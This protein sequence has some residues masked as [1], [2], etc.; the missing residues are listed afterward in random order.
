MM[1]IKK[2]KLTGLLSIL[3]IGMLIF[4]ACSNTPESSPIDTASITEEESAIDSIE[5]TEVQEP[6]NYGAKGAMLKA[7]YTLEEMMQY[8]IED[9]YLAYAEYELIINEM[10]ITKPFSNIIKAE[11]T[12]IGYMEDLYETYGFELPTIDPSQHVVLPESINDAFI[13]GVEAEIINIAMYESFLEQD[14]PEDVRSVFEKLKV[15]SES[16]LQAFKKNVR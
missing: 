13:A 7:E 16:H 6:E 4:T 11:A 14:L 10:N 3:I 1:T 2:N 8:A 9:E 12:H 5:E 15:G